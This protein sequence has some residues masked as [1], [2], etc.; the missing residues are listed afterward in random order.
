MAFGA[1]HIL[2]QAGDV[3][4]MLELLGLDAMKLVFGGQAGGAFPLEPWSSRR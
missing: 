1:Q 4:G 2:P 3:L